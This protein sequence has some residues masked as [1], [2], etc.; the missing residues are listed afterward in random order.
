MLRKQ[1]RDIGYNGIALNTVVPSLDRVWIEWRRS[2]YRALAGPENV[3][4][5]AG[6]E[7]QLGRAIDNVVVFINVARTKTH[8]QRNRQT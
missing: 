8:S 4:P 6:P 3:H 7:P 1:H 5:C 2:C